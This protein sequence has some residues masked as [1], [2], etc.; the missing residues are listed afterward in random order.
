MAALLACAHGGQVVVGTETDGSLVCPAGM[1]G[2]VGHKPGLGPVGRS[3]SYR[4]RP[5]GVVPVSAERDTAGPMARDVADAAL[6]LSVPSGRTP[7]ATAAPSAPGRGHPPGR[8][9]RRPDRLRAGCP[10]S[11]SQE[12]DAP[13]TRA[14]DRLRAAGAGVVEVTPPEQDRLAGL[15]V[16]ALLSGFRR[17]IDACLATRRGPRD[18]AGLIGPSRARPGEQTCSAGQGLFEEAR[19]T[20]PATGPE[21]RAMRPVPADLSRRSSDETMAEY[22]RGAPA[23]PRTRPCGPPAAPGATTT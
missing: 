1:N 20:P 8:P 17:D 23:S 6:A 4:S 9:A 19:A 21:Y 11:L 22:G 5:S 14:A 3:G 15:E 2:V 7:C 13:M 18:L 12:A 10:R 16:P